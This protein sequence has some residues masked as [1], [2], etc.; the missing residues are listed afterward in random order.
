LAPAVYDSEEERAKPEWNTLVPIEGVAQPRQAPADPDIDLYPEPSWR[1]ILFTLF[2]ANCKPWLQAAALFAL[3][4][5][6]ALLGMRLA[7]RI[8]PLPSGLRPAR[9]QVEKDSPLIKPRTGP[10]ARPVRKR[11]ATATPSAPGLGAGLTSGAAA[12]SKS[13]PG[14]L[15]LAASRERL[16]P[17][18]GRSRHA[19]ETGIVAPDT[20]VRYA[21]RPAAPDG[22]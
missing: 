21:P 3:G 8:S 1:E 13:T 14:K 7:H 12:E 18:P 4:V 19:A 2:S 22:K 6:T 5:V 15:S 17:V 10:V 16:S 11:R 20:V 9:T